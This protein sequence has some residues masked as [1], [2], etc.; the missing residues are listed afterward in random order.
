MHE[1][2]SSWSAHFGQDDFFLVLI[3]VNFLFTPI[4][5]WVKR[6]SYQVLNV[7]LHSSVGKES[8]CNAGD[9]GL[10]PGLGR[11][12][13]ERMATHSSALAWRIPWTKKPSSLQSMCSEESD[14][15]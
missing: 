9:L 12:P 11:S 3:H 1:G 15:T 4:N 7:Y 13:G 2:M 10:I 8:A 5:I 14:V 6:I